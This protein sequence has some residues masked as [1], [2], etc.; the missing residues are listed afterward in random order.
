MEVVHCSPI[1]EARDN[2]IRTVF[3]F[4]WNLI[5]LST[6][7]PFCLFKKV[8]ILRCTIN[9]QKII[10]TSKM[11]Y[12][13]FNHNSSWKS[14]G[15]TKNIIYLRGHS[16]SSLFRVST[17]ILKRVISLQNGKLLLY[18]L[19]YKLYMLVGLWYLSLIPVIDQLSTCSITAWEY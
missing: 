16:I 7:L 8:R 6:H 15:R 11:L 14:S 18:V 19:I 4:D 2:G 13:I 3:S 5:M 1:K 17:T 9:P 12:V 10:A